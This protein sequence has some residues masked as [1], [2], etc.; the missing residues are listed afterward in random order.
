[1]CFSLQVRPELLDEYRER[2]RN[3]WPEMQDALRRTGWN[4]Y[5]LFLRE[6]GL[7]IGYLETSNFQA[8]LDGMAKEEVNA[9]WQSQMARFFKGQPGKMAD[10]QMAVIPEVFHL[11]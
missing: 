4:N 2:H 3:V 1:V 7:L 5:S 11:D 10:E 9:R 8:A 6:D